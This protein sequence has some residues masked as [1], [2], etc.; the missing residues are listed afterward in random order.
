M[1]HGIRGGALTAALALLATTAAGAQSLESRV[2][3]R[4]NATV[5]LSYASRPGVC[6]GAN[7]NISMSDDRDHDGWESDCEKGPVMVTLALSGGSVTRITTR[8]G[9]HWTSREGVTD[10][11][12]VPAAQAAQLM[13]AIARKGSKAADDAI[14][15]A[16]LADSV[17]IW[18]QPSALRRTRT[19]TRTLGSPR[20][21]GSAR[22][23]PQPPRPGWSRWWVMTR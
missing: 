19:S 9:G 3:A 18:P 16:M 5:R 1:T 12:T 4:P 14:L 23:R 13:L 11:G 17:T 6:G 15:P 22:P 21:S 2:Y 7:G 8:V 20:S 10:L